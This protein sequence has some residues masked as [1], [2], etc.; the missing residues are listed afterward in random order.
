[1]SIIYMC[2]VVEWLYTCPKPTVFWI[3]KS[4]TSLKCSY[5]T[6]A[7]GGLKTKERVNAVGKVLLLSSMVIVR[8]SPIGEMVGDPVTNESTEEGE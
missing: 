6:S 7:R 8:S 1:M 4:I 3:A 5:R 2:T